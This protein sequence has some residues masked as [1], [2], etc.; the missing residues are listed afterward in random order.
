MLNYIKS[1]HQQ[2]SDSLDK[3]PYTLMHFDY[4]VSRKMFVDYCD[5]YLKDVYFDLAPLISIPLYQQHKTI[6]Y[7]YENK[8]NH[9]VTQA[10]AEAAANS[11]NVRLFEHPETR[12]AGVILKSRCTSKIGDADICEI[13]AHS[14]KGIDRVEYVP[15]HGGDGHMHD[16]PVH[17]IEYVPVYKV[18]PMIVKDTHQ[19][20]S[21]YEQNYSSSNYNDLINRFGAMS[22][23]IYKKR[24]FSFL[25][26]DNK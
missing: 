6:E 10:E 18:T 5:K 4:K 25:M 1:A 2:N 11:H 22:D 24:I 3:N 23:I 16:V 19:N 20:K 8:F 26:K 21:E 17:W 15:V 12:S 14:F 7:I 13:T 9:N